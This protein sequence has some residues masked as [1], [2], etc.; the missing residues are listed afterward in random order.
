MIVIDAKETLTHYEENLPTRFIRDMLANVE[1]PVLVVPN[2]FKEIRKIVLLYD[3]EP[4]SVYAIKMF[5]YMFP[6]MENMD[7]EIISV[8][9]NEKAMQNPDN[10]LMKEFIKRHFPNAVYTTLKGLPDREIVNYLKYRNEGEL[11][12]LGAYRRGSV[13]R[14]FKPSMADALIQ[15]LRSPIFIA[16]NK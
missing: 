10:R 2:A 3:G 13:S 14:W 11:I 7:T 9:T 16:H 8:K 5:S 15:E 12:V 6:D 1:C 4:S